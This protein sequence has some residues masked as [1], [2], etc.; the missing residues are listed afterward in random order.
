M[1]FGVIGAGV[2]GQMRARSV[3]LHPGDEVAAIS[4]PNV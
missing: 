3:A 4:D 2:I 1:R